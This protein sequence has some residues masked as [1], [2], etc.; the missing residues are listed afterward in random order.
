LKQGK[1]IE[2]KYEDLVSSPNET[3]GS[4]ID[5]FDLPK[6]RALA[7][8]LGDVNLHPHHD[9]VFNPPNTD[10]IGKGRRSGLNFSNAKIRSRLSKELVS[11]GYEE[12]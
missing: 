9:N 4:I 2:V 5:K 11:A 12:L 10:S 3:I 6:R 8:E 1:Y 7:G